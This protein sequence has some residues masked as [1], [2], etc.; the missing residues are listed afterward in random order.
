M[1][2]IVHGG[3]GWHSGYF[4]VLGKALQA[5]KFAAVAYD[6]APRSSE[7]RDGDEVGSGYSDGVPGYV[8]SYQEVVN[9]LQQRAEEAGRCGEV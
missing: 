5:E 7:L 6:Q 1:L 3:A 4:D 8:D 2:L 9:D